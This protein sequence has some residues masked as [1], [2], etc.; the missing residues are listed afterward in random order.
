MVYG[1]MRLS[2]CYPIIKPPVRFASFFVNAYAQYQIIGNDKQVPDDG[3]QLFDSLIEAVHN[4][5]TNF[6]GSS[7]HKFCEAVIVASENVGRSRIL[8]WFSAEQC[9]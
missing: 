5:C 3:M 6:V 9:I 4:R 8:C 7:F 2:V 1:R